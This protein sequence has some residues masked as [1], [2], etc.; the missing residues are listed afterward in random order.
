VSSRTSPTARLF[1][2]KHV[3]WEVGSGNNFA[4][5]QEWLETV[6]GNDERLGPGSSG[7]GG[8]DMDLFYRLLRAGAHIRYEPLC[9]I[10]H[11]RATRR[12]RL[13]RR[14]P[15]GHGVGAGIGIWLREGD[16]Y[17]PWV[18]VRWLAL[19]CRRLLAGAV[20]LEVTL[21]REEALVLMGTVR[22]LAFGLRAERRRPTSYGPSAAARPTNT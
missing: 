4:V 15:Y 18:L 10:R 20:R 19:R 1:S 8:V 17:A 21:V 3:P 9:R 16:A 12:D 6:G 7:K 13:A 14:E 22:G 2:G 11:E 5:R